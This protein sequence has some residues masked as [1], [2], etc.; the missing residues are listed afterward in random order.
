MWPAGDASR[1]GNRG[2]ERGSRRTHPKAC[3]EMGMCRGPQKNQDRRA[4]SGRKSK[5]TAADILSD[6]GC[7]AP[8]SSAP[9]Q[10]PACRKRARVRLAVANYPNRARSTEA[11]AAATRPMGIGCG[12]PNSST[13][14]QNN[15]AGGATLAV[16]TAGPAQ[17]TCDALHMTGSGEPSRKHRRIVAAA[18]PPVPKPV[19]KDAPDARLHGRGWHERW[20]PPELAKRRRT[21]ISLRDSFAMCA[22]VHTAAATTSS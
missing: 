14:G 11:R 5:R 12:A 20:P 15:A 4:H 6:N 21:H 3:T 10:R 8:S 17:R 2:S 9:F 16:R 19:R 18:N 1:C 13:C 7:G 22:A